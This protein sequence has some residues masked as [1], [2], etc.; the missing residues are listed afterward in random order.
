MKV[1]LIPSDDLNDELY[2]RVLSL[3]QAV[4]GVNKFIPNG[5]GR[6]L[7]PEDM[8]EDQEIPDKA[9]FE[10]KRFDYPPPQASMEPSRRTWT[11]PHIRR[12]VRWTDLF[13]EIQEIGRAHV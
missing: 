8:L 10:K 13:S 3:L 12:A 5:S 1:H 2:T 11:F 4:P 9:A 6:I 7:L